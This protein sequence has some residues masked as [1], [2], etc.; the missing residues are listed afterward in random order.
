ML[1]VILKKGMTEKEKLEY[2]KTLSVSLKE[3][4]SSN[5]ILSE[6]ELDRRIIEAERARRE[7]RLWIIAVISAIA[8]VVSAVAAWMAVIKN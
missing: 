4:Y 8:S 6:P 5:G 3:L 2:A 7:A 1:G